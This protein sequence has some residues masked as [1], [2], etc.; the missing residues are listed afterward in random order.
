MDKKYTA[1][2]KLGALIFVV[3]VVVWGFSLRKT[4]DLW[5]NYVSVRERLEQMQVEELGQRSLDFSDTCR[6]LLLPDGRLLEKMATDF[7]KEKVVVVGFTPFIS[8]EESGFTLH[9]GELLLSGGYIS[10]VRSVY[11]LEKRF[12]AVKIISADF[13]LY[14][15]NRNAPLQLRANLTVMQWG[16]KDK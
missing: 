8:Q 11:E 7:R 14:R 2:G 4:V 16:K 1:I 15:E 3:P 12:S 5:H 13:R 9:T 6:E 10:L